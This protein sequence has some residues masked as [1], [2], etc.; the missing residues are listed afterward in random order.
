VREKLHFIPVST[1]DSVFKTAIIGLWFW[2]ESM[3]C[4]L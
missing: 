3:A 4:D 2:V 1:V